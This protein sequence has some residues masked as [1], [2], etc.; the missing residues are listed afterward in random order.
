[1]SLTLTSVPSG[2]ISPLGVARLEVL[3]VARFGPERRVGLRRDVVR[4][5]IKREVIDVQRAEI[6][7]ERVPNGVERHVHGFGLG[8]VHVQVHLR[9]AG[10]E[11]G[12][13]LR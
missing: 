10:A 2:T 12:E 9:H 11:G 13:R 4:P 8:A 7:R 3:H 6:D 1:M 5:A